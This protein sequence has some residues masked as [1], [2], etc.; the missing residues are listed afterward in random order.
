MFRGAAKV[1]LDDKGRMVFPT[2]YRE[3]A[4]EK[5]QGRLVVTVDRDQCL[6][7]YPFPEWEQ[8]ATKVF[9]HGE[10]AVRGKQTP[11]QAMAALDKDVNGILE[12]RRWLMDHKTGR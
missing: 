8:I 5:S 2:R 4:L 11:A 9:E 6:L 7:I 10:Q 3:F 1:T 12:K